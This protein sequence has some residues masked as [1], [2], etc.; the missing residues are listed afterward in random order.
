LSREEKLLYSAAVDMPNST[1]VLLIRHASTDAVRA[2]LTGRHEGVAL[3]DNGRAECVR[4]ARALASDPIAA[5]YSSPME[6]ALD[7][8]RAIAD[9]HHLDVQ[10]VRALNEVDFGEWTGL[11]FQDLDRDPAWHHYNDARS[12]ARIP[13]GESASQVQARVVHALESIHA[14]HPGA[15]VAAVTHA[16]LIR[17]A[18]LYARG[19]PLDRWNHVEVA[20]ASIT[21][22]AWDARGARV[23][24]PSAFGGALA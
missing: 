8:A 10:I 20:P 4:L 7:T 3:N 21:P 15:L 24:T 16:E 11:T 6:R 19:E 14:S 5:V 23:L 18:V 12:T 13:G 9:V 17:Y 1:V 2:S 22:I